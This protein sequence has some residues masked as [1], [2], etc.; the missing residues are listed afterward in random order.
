[1]AR[2]QFTDEE[3]AKGARKGAPRGGRAVATKQPPDVCPRCN[4]SMTGRNWHSYLGH[5]GLHGVADR[6]FDG[7][8]AAAQRRLRKNGQARQDPYPGNGAF[9]PY[10]PIMERDNESQ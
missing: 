2:H 6:Y 5:L 7:D 9:A 10:R 8:T 3:R 4:E 1:M